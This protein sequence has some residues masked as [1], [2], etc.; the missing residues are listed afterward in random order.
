MNIAIKRKIDTL[1]RITIPKF[2]LKELNINSGDELEIYVNV[3]NEI[4]LKKV[5]KDKE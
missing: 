2:L 4:V 3:D 5:S 1:N